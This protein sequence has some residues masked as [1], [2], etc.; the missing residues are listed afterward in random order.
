M[1][2]DRF[3]AAV[4]AAA[5]V[6]LVTLVVATYAVLDSTA[7]GPYFAAVPVGPPVVA[8]LSLVGVVV[9]AAGVTGRSDAASMAGAAVVLG[10]FVA[11]LSWWWALSVSAALVGSLTPATSFAYHRWAVALAG[12]V[13]LLASALY[14]REVV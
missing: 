12:T 9:L 2:R 1:E 11:L 10:L 4:A 7:V 13:Q 5:A 14:A 3:A 6:L 8:L